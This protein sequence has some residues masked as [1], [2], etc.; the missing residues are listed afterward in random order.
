[1]KYIGI[2]RSVSRN[3]FFA[4]FSLLAV[5]V[6]SDSPDKVLA[7]RWGGRAIDD[8]QRA[9]REQIIN[10]EGMRDHREGVRD[11]TVLFNRDA[12]TEFR[13]NAEIRVRGTG[14]FSQNND[15]GDNDGRSRAFS[16]EAVVNNRNRNVSSVR[17]NWRGGWSGGAGGNYGGQRIYCASDDGRRRTCPVNTSVGIVRL[18]TQ[19]SGAACVQGRTWGYT[20]N[21]IWV[22][23]GCRA[24]FEV[25]RRRGDGKYGRRDAN[26]GDGDY[27]AGNRPDGRVSYSGPIINRHSDKALD[28]TEQQHRGMKWDGLAPFSDFLKSIRKSELNRSLTKE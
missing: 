28:V 10:Q 6:A 8:A 22:D 12:S 19:K 23:R 21:S 26:A 4:A 15:Y 18:M 11:P 13:S 14:V 20:R 17:Y 2:S 7:Q 25:G 1:M 5:I 24:D 9:V 16:Y 3:T 27:G